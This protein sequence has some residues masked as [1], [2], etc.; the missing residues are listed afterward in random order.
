[1]KT[2]ILMWKKPYQL[3]DQGGL[4]LRWQDSKGVFLLKKGY[5]NERS[6]TID[7]LFCAIWVFPK[8]GVPPNHP[9]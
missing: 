8:I 2:P 3:V 9:F 6:Q 7:D 5:K 4:G 1:M